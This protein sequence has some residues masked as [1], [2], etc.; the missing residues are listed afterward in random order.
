[1][2]HQHK[3]T[4][5]FATINRHPGLFRDSSFVDYNNQTTFARVLCGHEHKFVSECKRKGI[6]FMSYPPNFHL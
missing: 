2:P 5:I 1:M 4:S 3:E 6:H